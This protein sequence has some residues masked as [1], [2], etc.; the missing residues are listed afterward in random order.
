MHDVVKGELSFLPCQ[1]RIKGQGD[2]CCTHI[3]Q[4]PFPGGFLPSLT[5][6]PPCA[7]PLLSVKEEDWGCYLHP[8]GTIQI[9]FIQI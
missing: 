9:Y 3:K 7:L 8:S 6:P 5:P 1:L 4:P 2:M